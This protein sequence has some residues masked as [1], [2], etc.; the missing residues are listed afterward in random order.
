MPKLGLYIQ[1]ALR[2]KCA[3]SHDSAQPSQELASL[4]ALFF[5]TSCDSADSSWIYQLDGR[6][7]GSA[8]RDAQREACV[9]STEN[10]VV[11][12]VDG[13]KAHIEAL[14]PNGESI[15]VADLGR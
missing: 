13:G 3:A 12:K 9:E 5:Y 11:V 2:L 1:L 10:F 6:V 8:L 15:D 7:L 4:A 14:K